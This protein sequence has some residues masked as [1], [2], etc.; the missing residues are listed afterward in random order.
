MTDP[1]IARARIEIA[2][3]RALIKK[4]K[5]EELLSGLPR[6]AE[7]QARMAALDRLIAANRAL[8]VR[9]NG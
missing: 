9:L 2:S 4:L 6:S 3:D 1:V 7:T 8:L 5:A